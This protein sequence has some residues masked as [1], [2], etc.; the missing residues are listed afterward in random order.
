MSGRYTDEIGGRE[1]Y[2]EK[3]ADASEYCFRR[4]EW[5]WNIHQEQAT[6]MNA[7]RRTTRPIASLSAELIEGV[8][9][10]STEELRAFISLPSFSLNSRKLC[11]CS[12]KMEVIELTDWHVS[13]CLANG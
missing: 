4:R 9:K 10:T 11:T 2:G 12:W 3:D 13:S 5:L 1:T 6:L 8:H 7:V